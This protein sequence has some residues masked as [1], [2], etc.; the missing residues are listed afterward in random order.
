MSFLLD[1][2]ICSA[3]LKRPGQVTHR[4]FQHVGSL[5]VST[6]IVGELYVWAF[7]R[8]NPEIL[9][10][11]IEDELLAEMTVLPYTA[12]C[13][14]EYGRL[15]AAQL[16]VGRVVNPV[17]LMIA[18]TALAHGLTVVTNNVKDFAGIPDLR[19]EDWLQ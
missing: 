7:R 14:R 9:L 11:A 10:R 17:D 8:P 3:F 5:H 4:F 2:N 19:V 16:S 13:A 12:P 1:T 18:A 15:R 6:V